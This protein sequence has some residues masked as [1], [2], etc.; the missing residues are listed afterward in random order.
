MNKTAISGEGLKQALDGTKLRLDLVPPQMVAAVAEVLAF[1]AKKYAAHNWMKGIQWSQIAA[2]VKRH[3][4][5]FEM[6]EEFDPESHLPHLAHAL[7]GLTFLHWY[8]HGPSAQAYRRGRTAS[9]EPLDDRA[10]SAPS[11][12]IILNDRLEEFLNECIPLTRKAGI[13]D[14]WP[15]ASENSYD[16]TDTSR[17]K[18]LGGG[19]T[20]AGTLRA[21]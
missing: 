10:F 2:G 8:A 3:V 20:A 5:A 19:N 18:S 15:D 9:H 7:C 1:G 11:Q 12:A 21:L 17:A 13:I 4:A 6:G 16:A 14:R